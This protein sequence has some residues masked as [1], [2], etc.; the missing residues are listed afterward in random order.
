MIILNP[1]MRVTQ[2]KDKRHFN[3]TIPSLTSEIISINKSIYKILKLINN[4]E[5]NSYECLSK[6]V[7]K[8][9]INNL[10]NNR[11]IID[12]NEFMYNENFLDE[13]N[14][15]FP[16]YT[17]TIE[18]TNGCNLNCIH[19]Y[20][21]FGR[22]SQKKRYS[23]EE[24]TKLKNELDKLHTMEV[25]LSGG[26]CFLNPDFE[27][28]A[29]FFLENGFRIS[30]YTNGYETDKIINFAE[31]TKQYNYFMGISLDGTETYHNLIRGKADAYQKVVST[32]R[33]LNT[34][35]NI[36]ILI[37]T[38]IMRQNIDDV[39]NVKALCRKVF[40][41]YD[42]KI[43]LATPVNDTDFSFDYR[44]IP[45]VVEKCPELFQDYFTGNKKGIL[46]R[47]R[48]RC[49]GGIGHGVLTVDGILK[50]CPIAEEEVFVIGDIRKKSLYDV[51]VNPSDTIKEFRK[52][53]EK[54]TPQCKKCTER[55][56]CGSKNCRIEALRLT[57]EYN[58]SSPYTCMAV[59][60]VY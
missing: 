50:M 52:E 58:N 2:Q 42:Q 35:S 56:R 39:E 24:I 48:H 31:S 15:D 23:F 30:I 34:Y 51:W 4:N 26:E 27:K 6:V 25:R 1:N 22:P 37:A 36:D 16:L 29:K 10:Y 21:K 20:G 13:C 12:S 46:L 59:K 17:I 54:E 49:N 19:C 57:G 18:L 7:G 53:Y 33:K 45:F 9:V 14:L 11:I 8:S 40:P 41:E 60:G 47:K 43:F 44:E 38:A 32:L 5:I 3:V 55:R 28:I